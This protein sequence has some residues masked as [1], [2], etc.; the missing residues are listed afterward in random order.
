MKSNDKI[1]D[2]TKIIDDPF[3]LGPRLGHML[4]VMI[5]NDSISSSNKVRT[6]DEDIKEAAG[7][8]Y[9]EYLIN[10][11]QAYSSSSSLVFNPKAISNKLINKSNHEN[12]QM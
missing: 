6:G 2:F 7:D 3:G 1:S 8:K 9:F 5:L 10:K 11:I 12:K 4:K